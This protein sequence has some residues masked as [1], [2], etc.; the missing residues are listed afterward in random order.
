MQIRPT[1]GVH[2]EAQGETRQKQQESDEDGIGGDVKPGQVNASAGQRDAAENGLGVSR[3]RQRQEQSIPEQELQDQRNVAEQLD[4]CCAQKLGHAV[5]GGPHDPHGDADDCCDR[6]RYH[7]QEQGVQ[8]A[9]HDSMGVGGI[10]VILDQREADPPARRAFQ[11]PETRG[12]PLRFKIGAA[13]QKHGHDHQHQAADKRHLQRRVA[14]CPVFK[15]R[16]HLRPL[17]TRYEKKAGRV[18]T[19]GPASAN[20]QSMIIG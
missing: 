18:L 14:E 20:D 5:A 1:L 17:R 4:E 7:S 9:D 15:K 13:R 6:Q 10:G 8:D 11:E 12:H 2:P 19:P 3:A 16:L